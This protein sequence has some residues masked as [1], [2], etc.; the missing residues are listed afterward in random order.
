MQHTARHQDCND[1]QPLLVDKQLENDL[2]LSFQA[3]LEPV[4]PVFGHHFCHMSSRQS[5]KLYIVNPRNNH[6]HVDDFCPNP[7]RQ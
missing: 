4:Q 5:M 3:D 1:V 7:V 2:L 6:Q